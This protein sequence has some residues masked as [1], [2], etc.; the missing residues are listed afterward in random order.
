MSHIDMNR[1]GNFPQYWTFSL[2]PAGFSGLICP[3]LTRKKEAN[4]TTSTHVKNNE[5]HHCCPVTTRDSLKKKQQSHATLIFAGGKVLTGSHQTDQRCRGG[6]EKRERRIKVTVG[7]DYRASEQ[8]D[9]QC[10]RERGSERLR[11]THPGHRWPPP[12]PHVLSPGCPPRRPAA[13]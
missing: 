3:Q 10:P 4:F 13:A 5:Q 7:G 11:E 2:I 1:E 6:R 12:R 9:E 8:K